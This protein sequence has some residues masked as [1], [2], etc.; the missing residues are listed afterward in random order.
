MLLLPLE[1][2][3]HLYA[4]AEPLAVSSKAVWLTS[5][6]LTCQMYLAFS[7]VGDVCIAIAQLRGK[8]VRE[9]CDA[10]Y[11]AGGFIGLW[12]RL[13]LGL[14]RG[15]K[16]VWVTLLPTLVLVAGV[17]ALWRGWSLALLLWL[18]VQVLLIVLESWRGKSL[19]AP[20]P[21]PLRVILV[22]LVMIITNV[23]LVTPD[24]KLALDRLWLMFSAAKPT[25]YS[26]MLDKRLAS[27][28][29]QSMLSIAVLVCVG[30]PPLGWVLQQSAKIWQV[31]GILLLP[32]SL[33]MAL[34]ESWMLPAMI[35][36][37]TQ[38]PVIWLFGEG[39]S[40]V[41]HGYEGWLFPQ[42]ELDRL[43]LKRVNPSA[44]E[45]L[46]VLA[47]KLKATGVPLFV[48]AMPTKAALYPANIL[49]A[50]YNAPVQPPGQK[51][52]LEQ[53]HAAG[54]EVLDPSQVLWDRL[55]RAEAY[56]QN[57]SH[58]KPETM[59]EVALLAAKQIRKNWPALHLADTPLINATI[60]DRTDVG[61]LAKVLLPLSESWFGAESAQLVSIRGLASD[62]KSPVLLVGGELLRV[63]ED[64]NSSF[65][66]TSDQPQD[67][68]FATQLA[69]LLG[70]PLEVQRADADKIIS[71]NLAESAGKK[72]LVIFLLPADEL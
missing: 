14:A 20:L 34:R 48:I 39:N 30:L 22:M 15:C 13:H 25:L 2:M 21:Q 54:I 5:L 64:A 70:R 53:L 32:V 24:L 55:I 57:D 72:K 3:Q 59:K 23:L 28:W 35:Q 49:S 45:S 6:T 65:G 10:P 16:T 38:R 47:E 26:L 50:E 52:K 63:Y 61:D 29:Q 42:S 27:N 68:G 1:W 60:L 18:V 51:A 67:A 62:P 37:I 4:N 46:V 31:V 43:T 17:A 19:F 12:Q 56:F 58:W 41:Y 36:M 33:L 44:T 8:A 66:N 71:D 7:G 69:S 11:R 9:F 40:R